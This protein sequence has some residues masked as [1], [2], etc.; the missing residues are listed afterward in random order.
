[1]KKY[2]LISLC[3]LLC[4][5]TK[6]SGQQSRNWTI[7][8]ASD[9]SS[10]DQE[11]QK[12]LRQCIQLLDSLEAYQLHISGHTDNRGSQAYNLTLSHRRAKAVWNFLNDA[13]ADSFNSVLDAHSFSQ[14]VA[15]NQVAAGRSQNR[16]VE[17][18][19]TE[20][21]PPEPEPAVEAAISDVIPEKSVE[22]LPTEVMI[23]REGMVL[24]TSV[25][26]MMIMTMNS[27]Q[28]K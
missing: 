13:I 24:S 3:I 7:Y 21:T 27:A 14:P 12:E 20:L 22:E 4:S 11:S 17:I 23:G 1:M 5:I 9:Q 6:L 16:R 15:S 28:A 18:V 2:C 10:L 8:F 25:S 19:L 26:A